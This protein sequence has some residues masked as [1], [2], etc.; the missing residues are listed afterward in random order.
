MLQCR[1]LNLLGNDYINNLQEQMVF[2][3]DDKDKIKKLKMTIAHL[4]I[5]NF[6]FQAE[7][8]AGISEHGKTVGMMHFLFHIDGMAHLAVFI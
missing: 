1:T 7:C 5:F 2:I 3:G 6:L 4:T 8:R